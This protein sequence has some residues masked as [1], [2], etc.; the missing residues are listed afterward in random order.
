MDGFELAERGFELAEDAVKMLLALSTGAIVGWERERKR[1][2]AGLKTHMMVALGSALLIM[3]SIDFIETQ[4]DQIPGEPRLLQ[5]DLLRVV[6]G[7]IGGIGFLGGGAIIQH[8]SGVKGLTTASTIWVTAAIGIVCGLGQWG[9]ALLA[10]CGVFG[11][12]QV[13]GWLMRSRNDIETQSSA[14]PECDAQH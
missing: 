14:S 12:L 13:F 3:T 7:I 2:P 8:E 5:V 1:R 10:I 4:R 9:L 6:S 11:V